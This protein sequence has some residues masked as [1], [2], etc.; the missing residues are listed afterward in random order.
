V[1]IP[2]H[3]ARTSGRH[4]ARGR[5]GCHRYWLRH[6]ERFVPVPSGLQLKH[7]A[8][9]DR[10]DVG[11]HRQG[12]GPSERQRAERGWSW[13]IS[14]RELTSFMAIIRRSSPPSVKLVQMMY[15]GFPNMY[16]MLGHNVAPGHTSV[17]INIDVQA[18]YIA[19]V[20]KAQLQGNSKV[21][22]VKREP[23]RRYME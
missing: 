16:I 4:Y 10:L 13:S 2:S 14:R 7:N 18:K 22:E 6:R 11:R 1:M 3:L 9:S 17:M 8:Y 21:I 20:V 19:Q 5:R 12:F 23:T 15:P